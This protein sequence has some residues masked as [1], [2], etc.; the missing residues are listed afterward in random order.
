MNR[1]SLP[2]DEVKTGLG[3]FPTLR[4]Y[5]TNRFVGRTTVNADAELRWSF[6]EFTVWEQHLK[7]AL[8]TFVDT[9][10]VFDTLGGFSAERWKTSYGVGFP[11]GLEPGDGDQ[12]RLRHG[13][14]RQSLLHAAR[15]ALLEATSGERIFAP[16]DCTF[17][18]PAE[19]GNNGRSPGIVLGYFSH[20][21]PQ[22][23]PGDV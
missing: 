14:R 9:G 18:I 8:A 6:S 1:L 17:V 19:H 13:P 4:G 12:L 3:G 22:R 23:S 20:A 10:R 15:P 7:T 5:N 16:C 11:A 21:V 2:K